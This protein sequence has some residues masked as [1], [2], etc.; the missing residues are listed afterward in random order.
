M[1][2][3]M[4]GAVVNVAILIPLFTL[5]EMP[6]KENN[7]MHFS[8]IK[9]RK[10]RDFKV[11]IYCF[12]AIIF[13]RYLPATIAVVANVFLLVKLLRRYQ[14]RSFQFANRNSRKDRTRL[15][16]FGTTVTLLLITTFLVL[17]FVPSATAQILA[18][19]HPDVYL[20]V[21]SKE[22]SHYNAVMAFGKFVSAL[23]EANH[24][25]VYILLSRRSRVMFEHM[26]TKRR[27]SCLDKRPHSSMRPKAIF[28][29]KFVGSHF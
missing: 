21:H 25:V 3:I 24:F 19:F 1:I 13:S 29:R 28:T 22:H 27:C 7:F 17:S 18:H 12:I 23:S 8:V 20:N 6:K 11:V 16:D 9:S 4:S 15:D 2:V 26:I 10:D 14:R 5:Q